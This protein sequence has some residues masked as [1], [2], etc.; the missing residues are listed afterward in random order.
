MEVASVAAMA[1]GLPPMSSASKARHGRSDGFPLKASGNGSMHTGRSL[2][3]GDR[4]SKEIR[5]I[6]HRPTAKNMPTTATGLKYNMRDRKLESGWLLFAI[7]TDSRK[8]QELQD[9]RRERTP[10]FEPGLLAPSLLQPGLRRGKRI[11]KAQA[12]AGK[13]SS[14]L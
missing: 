13:R 14:R 2:E 5:R 3:S 6:W 10:L 7:S 8:L 4:M 11:L 12:A 1:T 9:R